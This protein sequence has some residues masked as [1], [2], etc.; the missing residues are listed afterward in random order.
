MIA[1]EKY[2]TV[3]MQAFG[4]VYDLSDCRVTST[5]VREASR[6]IATESFTRI[7]K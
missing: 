7:I 4:K 6:L 3:F 5:I 1:L 2:E